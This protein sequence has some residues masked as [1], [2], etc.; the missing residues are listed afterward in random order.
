MKHLL[1][2]LDDPILYIG[3]FLRDSLALV[4][5]QCRTLQNLW[6]HK[7]IEYR[8]CGYLVKNPLEGFYDW[9]NHLRATL[10]AVCGLHSFELE[11]FS[12]SIEIILRIGQLSCIGKIEAITQILGKK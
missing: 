2:N 1:T 6:K 9:D 11:G 8:F 3:V 10:S 4:C 7:A 12:A 5:L